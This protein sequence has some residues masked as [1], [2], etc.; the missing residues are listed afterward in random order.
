MRNLLSTLPALFLATVATAQL[1]PVGPFTG[2]L[3]EEFETE[4]YSSCVPGRVFRNHA[5]L[6]TPGYSGLIVTYG[7]YLYYGY[8]M[9]PR[10]D[11]HSFAGT[12]RG[13]ANLVFDTPVQRFGAYF[14]TVGYLAGGVAWFFDDQDRLLTTLPISAPRGGWAWNGWDAGH[15]GTKIKRVEM[16]ANDPY[17][18]GALLCMEDAEMDIA[19]GTITR[20]PI[21]CGTLTVAATGLPVIGETITFTLA[22]PPAPRGFVVGTPIAALPIPA[23]P[24]CRLGVDG[25]VLA[26]SRFVLDIPNNPVFLDANVGAQG[27]ALTSG[28]CLGSVAISDAIDVWVGLGN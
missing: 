16:I 5:D 7:W 2:T 15:G 25:F 27:F 10:G 6:C 13:H 21:G 24:T 23:C 26:G 22:G 3:H 4:S 19:V 8:A 1:Q 14:G 28:P 12:T 20:R 9:Y 11:S 17:N 18:G